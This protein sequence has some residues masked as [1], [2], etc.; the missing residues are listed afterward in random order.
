MQSNHFN[1]TFYRRRCAKILTLGLFLTLLLTTQ[2]AQAQKGETPTSALTAQTVA[3][4]TPLPVELPDGDADGTNLYFNVS[5]INGYVHRV[6]L[7]FG[8]S[9]AHT[10]GGDVKAV[11]YSPGNIPHT[12]FDRVGETITGGAGDSS[13]LAGPYTFTDQGTDFWTAAANAGSDTAI[14]AGFYRTTSAGSPD[15]TSMDATFSGYGF[16]GAGLKFEGMD[17]QLANGMWRLNV[18]DNAEGDT[19]TVSTAQLTIHY[20]LATS[21]NAAVSGRV[22][23]GGSGIRNATVILNGGNLSEPL[24]T[25]TNDL[26]FYGFSDLPSGQVYVVTVV[27]RKYRFT[28]P[29]LIVN[30]QSDISDANFSAEER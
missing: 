27:S 13:D 26:G 2:N 14:P 12:I 4:L 20:S 19:G 24:V 6:E 16:G 9:P 15:F 17:A 5:G 1:Q 10:W 3:T 30:L 18:S 23:S 11:L 29:S 25:K 22:L 28:Q 7:T 8:F 21:A